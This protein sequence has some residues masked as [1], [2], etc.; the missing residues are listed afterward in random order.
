MPLAIYVLTPAANLEQQGSTIKEE[1]QEV[2][3]FIPTKRKKNR[4]KV[5][6]GVVIKEVSTIAGSHNLSLLSSAR[7]CAVEKRRMIN[8]EVP[9]SDILT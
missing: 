7:F 9:S 6:H 5:V 3:T 2:D 1:L 8:I 4:R